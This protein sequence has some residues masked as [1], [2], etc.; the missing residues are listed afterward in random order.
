LATIHLIE[1]PVG[2]GK[3][4][5]AVQLSN[6]HQA[7]KL[8]LDEW[9]ATLFS[10]DRPATGVVEWYLERK[11]RCIDQIWQLALEVIESGS[12]VVLELGLIRQADRRQFFERIDSAGHHLNIYVL[13]APLEDRRERVRVRNKNRGST[14]AMEVPDHVFEMA[15]AMWEPLDESEC[16]GYE[17][18][19]ISTEI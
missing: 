9:M 5:F 1:G 14:Y 2:S 18:Q 11:D 19:F 3:S 7:P 15:N 8:I 16:G 13:D 17:I 4:T 12:D 10:P 6:E